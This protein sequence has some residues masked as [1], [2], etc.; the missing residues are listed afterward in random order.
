M[1]GSPVLSGHPYVQPRAAWN[2][3]LDGKSLTAVYAPRLISL[4]LS[5]RR[6]EEADELEIV[7]DDGDGLF[8]PPPQGSILHVSLGWLRGSGVT[9]GLVDKGS[10]IIDEVSWDSSPD[11]TSIR[12]RS[13]DFKASFRTRRNKVWNDTTLGAIVGEVAGSHG[14]TSRCHPDLATQAVGAAEQGNKSDMQFMRDLARRYDAT[15]T[16]KAGHLIFAPIG[17]TTT[18]TGAPVPTAV[19]TR[20]KGS[21]ASW[22]RCARDKAQD[23]AEAQW[24]DRKSGKRKTK[25]TGGDNPKRLKRVYS[26]EGDAD[27]ASKA[28]HRRLQRASATLDI[29]LALGDPLLSPG[30]R[31]TVSGYKPHID[32]G[33]WLIASVD[34]AMDARGLATRVQMEVA[35]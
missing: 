11:R 4:R 19:I 3:S 25:G 12:A 29:D 1:A 15:C 33:K 27:A 2:V 10:F 8:Q 24:H 20:T 26:S 35:A 9:P 23:G 16:V 28:E 6:G 14:L 18:A 13:A 17:A 21:R 30:M 34:H 31:V 5:E 32:A 7:V 22:K